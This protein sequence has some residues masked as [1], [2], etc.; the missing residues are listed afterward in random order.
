VADSLQSN[1]VDENFFYDVYKGKG[2]LD[3]K[4]FVSTPYNSIETF[5]T[6]I[7]GSYISLTR[8]QN[9]A[10]AGVPLIEDFQLVIPYQDIFQLQGFTDYTNDVFGDISF[11]FS[12]EKNSLV[13]AFV[14][15]KLTLS[16]AVIEGLIPNDLIQ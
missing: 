8:L 7:C 16:E 3:N 12:L 13:W 6:S 10:V 1:T 2:Q 9:S 11:R 14:N 5:D 4:K 15:P